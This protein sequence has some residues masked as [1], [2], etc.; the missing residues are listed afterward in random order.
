MR[1]LAPLAVH[2]A[3]GQ[4]VAE[5]T[6]DGR[7]T[8]NRQDVPL[9]EARRRFHEVF[10]ARRDKT[11]FVIGAPSVRYGEIMAIIDAATGKV[12]SGKWK[13]ESGRSTFHFLLSTFHFPL[14][15][16]YFFVPVVGVAP[17]FFWSSMARSRRMSASWMSAFALTGST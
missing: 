2:A 8:I 1:P 5:Y 16:C 9:L 15:K 14:G 4:V 10:A 17:C 6:A 11:L 3:P 13:V 12:E 7:L